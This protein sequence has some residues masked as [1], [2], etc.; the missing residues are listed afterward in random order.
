MLTTAPRTAQD[1]FWGSIALKRKREEKARGEDESQRG[2]DVSVEE[3]AGQYNQDL[4]PANIFA[5]DTSLFPI[6]FHLERPDENARRKA[7]S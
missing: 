7:R 4:F 6:A 1:H 3:K 2:E 5:Q